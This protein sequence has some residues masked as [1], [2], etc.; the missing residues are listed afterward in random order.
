MWKVMLSRNAENYLKSADYQLMFVSMKKPVTLALGQDTRAALDEA[1]AQQ[2]R[3][4]S[5]VADNAIREWLA[6]HRT[7]AQSGAAGD[8]FSQTWVK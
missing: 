8:T 1:A 3:S 5:W 6:A 2:D 7:L 4:R